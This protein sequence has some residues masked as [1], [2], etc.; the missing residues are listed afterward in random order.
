[1]KRLISAVLF[2]LTAAVIISGACAGKGVNDSISIRKE[3][4]GVRT[5]LA[6]DPGYTEELKTRRVGKTGYFYIL[7]SGGVI[8]FHP[9]PFLLGAD[10]SKYWFVKDI[11]DKKQGCINYALAEKEF[12]VFHELLPGGEIL[13]LTIQSSE[14]VDS[15]RVCRRSVVGPGIE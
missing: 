15:T 10:Y 5:R 3:L 1:M 6:S 8:K 9:Q 4:Q 13:C 12:T 11:L 7:T 2:P 14:V